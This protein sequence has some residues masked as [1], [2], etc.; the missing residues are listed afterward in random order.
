MNEKMNLFRRV[1]AP[2]DWLM[3]LATITIS[4]FML[5]AISA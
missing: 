4:A 5:L 2:A 1:V 3:M